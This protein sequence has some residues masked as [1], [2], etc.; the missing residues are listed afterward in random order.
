M[1]GYDEW[2][3]ELDAELMRTHGVESEDV[4][5]FDPGEFYHANPNDIGDARQTASEHMDELALYTA[6]L[7]GIFIGGA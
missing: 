7:L 6:L 2:L 5:E 4:P 1:S 3:A